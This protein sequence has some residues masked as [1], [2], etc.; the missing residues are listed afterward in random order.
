VPTST[1][2]ESAAAILAKAEAF[3][4]DKHHLRLYH[5]DCLDILAALPEESIDLIFA[6]P[7]Y[8]EIII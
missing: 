3:R 7:P 4:D 8:S 6:D 5:A 1:L 2:P